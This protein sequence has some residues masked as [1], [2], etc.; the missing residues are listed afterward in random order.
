M[1]AKEISCIC[2][3]TLTHTH[4]YIYTYTYVFHIYMYICGFVYLPH[5]PF[6]CQLLDTASALSISFPSHHQ[7]DTWVIII[8]G[9]R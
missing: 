4:I 6:M 9:R 5:F 1:I 7:S 3:H 2:V 8:L